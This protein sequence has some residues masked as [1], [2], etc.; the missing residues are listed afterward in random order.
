MLRVDGISY[1]GFA[2][3]YVIINGYVTGVIYRD[4]IPAPIVRFTLVQFVMIS[5][6]GKLMNDSSIPGVVNWYL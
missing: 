5:Y 6:C 2:V 1:D 4:E 3:V